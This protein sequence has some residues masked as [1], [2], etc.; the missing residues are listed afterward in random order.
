MDIDEKPQ[1]KSTP[2]PSKLKYDPKIKSP[3]YD[4]PMEELASFEREMLG[5]DVV[6]ITSLEHL[7]KY[8]KK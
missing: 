4:A 7:Q 8:I 6:E 5:P 1:E 3:E 2:S